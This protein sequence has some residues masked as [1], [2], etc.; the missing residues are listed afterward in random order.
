MKKKN[1]KE[2]KGITLVALVITIIILLILAIVAINAVNGDGIIEYSKKA[3]T[4]TKEEQA[5]ESVAL[6]MQ[7]WKL[8]TATAD[9]SDGEFKTFLESKLPEE[10]II[11]GESSPFTVTI[12]N[13]KF[14]VS[15]NGT[16]ELVVPETPAETAYSIGDEVTVGT[17]QFYVIKDSP[18]TEETVILLAKNSI[19]NQEFCAF[20]VIEAANPVYGDNLNEN[21]HII[22]DTSSAVSKARE[23]AESLGLSKDAGRLMEESEVNALIGSHSDIIFGTDGNKQSNWWLATAMNESEVRYVDTSI[24]F[25][26]FVG[27]TG[28]GEHGIRPVIE[29]SKDKIS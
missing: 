25:V 14:K 18:A 15:N 9:K 28:N 21:A 6:A 8:A 11:E 22:A 5:K 26:M 16:Q 19:A 12:G 13:N 1:L 2:N 29:I 7:E 3:K 4:D 20:E 10:A 23:Y 27:V 24:N 17:E